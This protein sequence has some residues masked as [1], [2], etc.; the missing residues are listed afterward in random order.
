[1]ARP[2][3]SLAPPPV[4]R[5]AVPAV[6]PSVR[7]P[8]SSAEAASPRRRHY[9]AFYGLE[10]LPEDDG[11][12]LVIVLGN[13]QAEST[14]VLLGER[15]DAS[16]R[17]VRVPPV[18]E[19]VEGDLPHLARLL[20]HVDVLVTQPVRDDYRGLPLGTA[21]VARGLRAGAR[22]VRIP[23]LRYAGLYPRHVIVRSG[24]AGEAG[25]P[26]VAPYHDLATALL[27]AGR[28][29]LTGVPEDGVRAIA[30]ESVAQV[31]LRERRHD[32]VRASDLLVPAGVEAAH[33]I[34]HPGNPVL[35]G[36]ARRVQ[37][38]LGLPVDAAD[39]GRTLLRSIL[40]PV[41]PETC[42]ALRLPEED[43]REAWTIHG[44]AVPEE[45]IRERHLAWYAEHPGLAEHVLDARAQTL[46]HLQ[47]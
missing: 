11:R 17:S 8:E 2:T 15:P 44:R 3:E 39:P 9:G 24:P 25:D 21:Q 27:A 1:M 40:A 20:R 22:I 38:R 14:R 7:C 30:R 33:T 42:R 16:L 31:E 41:L 35:V 45:E 18:F 13:C 29:R 19:L 34:N 4:P 23:P 32:T 36:M 47:G 37:E 46:R 28:G 26:P 6:A 12:P 10:P 5:S 43:V